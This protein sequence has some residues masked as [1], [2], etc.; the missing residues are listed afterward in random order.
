W[1]IGPR[2]R[3]NLLLGGPPR[4]QANKRLRQ[5]RG[6]HPHLGTAQIYDIPAWV[7]TARGATRVSLL[8]DEG[9]SVLRLGVDIGGP[10]TDVVLT[11][12]ARKS[13]WVVKQLTTPDDPSI[14]LLSGATE[15][16]DAAGSRLAHVSDFVHGTTLASNVVLE[17]K[18]D[19]IA[20]LTTRGF[21]DVLLI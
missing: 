3:T 18:G 8:F 13:L 6:A 7:D 16:L 1:S 19:G 17:R 2:C 15:A 11:G 10:F 21:R 5:C 14:A 20:L 12:S 4:L 9:V